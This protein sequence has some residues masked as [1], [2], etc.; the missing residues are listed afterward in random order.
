M[1]E[2][3]DGSM[4]LGKCDKYKLHTLALKQLRVMYGI[5]VCF[6]KS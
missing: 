2:Q 6:W 3:T 4:D 1:N 5:V